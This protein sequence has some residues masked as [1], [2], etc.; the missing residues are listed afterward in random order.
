MIG[1]NRLDRTLPTYYLN[2][3]VYTNSRA[4]T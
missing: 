3:S 1:A 4:Y 2:R